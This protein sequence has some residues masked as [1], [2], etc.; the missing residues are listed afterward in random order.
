MAQSALQSASRTEAVRQAERELEAW[1]VRAIPDRSAPLDAD[2]VARLVRDCLH[3]LA[4]DHVAAD[5]SVNTVHYYRRK[6]I[7]DAPEGR[8]SAARYGVR[9]LW[10]AVGAR[11]AGQLGLVTLAE[12]R[13]AMRDESEA[14]LAAFVVERV[15]D[16]RARH[17]VRRASVS[18]LD[19]RPLVASSRSSAT[20]NV[21]AA[22]ARALT[23]EIA[24]SSGMPSVVFQLSEGA[25]CVLPAAHPA[26]QSAEAARALARA[27]VDALRADP[28]FTP[29]S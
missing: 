5:F 8:T 10:Q 9:H 13:E 16:A 12:A 28:H 2:D 6:D 20:A 4:L 29:E 17:A 15:A 18:A 27:L 22:S 23:P 25:W 3:A 1:R 19:A 21:I 14:A 7:L 24:L 26:R 11:L